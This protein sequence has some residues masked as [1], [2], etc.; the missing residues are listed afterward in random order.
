MSEESAVTV[1]VDADLSSA[2]KK[3]EE[4]TD[5]IRKGFDSVG[6]ASEKLFTYFFDAIGELSKK[7][8]EVMADT[9]SQTK[10]ASDSISKS[11]KADSQTK[12]KGEP[13]RGEKDDNKKGGENS[14]TE[15]NSVKKD[16]KS[17]KDDKNN[18]KN[19]SEIYGSQL[20]KRTHVGGL[21]KT[22]SDV[23]ESIDNVFYSYLSGT[24]DFS[25]VFTEG[26]KKISAVARN[27]SM[28]H[29]IVEE[30]NDF[31]KKLV[32]KYDLGKEADKDSKE[33]SSKG[34]DE[35]SKKDDADASKNNK[36]ENGDKEKKKDKKSN[37]GLGKYGELFGGKLE[38]LTG[39]KGGKSFGAES[40]SAFGKSMTDMLTKT[41]SF[42]QA[43]KSMYQE[44]RESFVKNMVVEPLRE[45]MKSLTTMLAKKLAFLTTDTTAT[46]T[47]A[48]TNAT[49]KTTEATTVGSANIME[50][51]TG[52]LA[53]MSSIPYVGPALAIAAV[54]AILAAGSRI[55]GSVA[56]ASGGYDIPAGVNPMTQLHE[57]E[58]V[59]PAHI[60][61]PLRSMIASGGDSS[62]A[63]SGDTHVHISA[64]DARS[65]K[66][67]FRDNGRVITDA[68][69]CAVKDGYRA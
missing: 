4:A 14:S 36:T 6:E 5:I 54:G 39:L 60:A 8:A 32:K 45:W 3:T 15:D 66:R 69:K 31:D 51:A 63:G 44:I 26:V 40:F 48:T 38:A 30:L 19:I 50:G 20:E 10:K 16:K 29:M 25:S 2:T 65:V 68:V 21:G 17:D 49:T 9:D 42:K 37:T 55:M 67:L 12:E 52:A 23:A 13:S 22:V 34:G 64:V 28:S 35:T 62:S 57:Q 41:K 33:D 7:L 46:A 43:M 56:S 59:L 11:N 61:N 53:A 27:S 24:K 18:T 58:M 1:K 47:A